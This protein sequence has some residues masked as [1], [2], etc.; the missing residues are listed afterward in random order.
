MDME[1]IGPWPVLGFDVAGF[2]ARDRRI[3]RSL[4]RRR[5]LDSLLQM[6]R[7]K[8]RIKLTTKK[9]AMAARTA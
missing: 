1:W 8:A 6:M 9:L 2:R 3:E 4:W 5:C 7:T